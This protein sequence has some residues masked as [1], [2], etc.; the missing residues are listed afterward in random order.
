[1][2]TNKLKSRKQFFLVGPV[3]AYAFYVAM[4]IVA[5]AKPNVGGDQ[6]DFRF[7]TFWG[8][9]I[10]VG[11]AGLSLFSLIRKKS[12]ELALFMIGIGVSLAVI[13]LSTFAIVVIEKDQPASYR[14]QDFIRCLVD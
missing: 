13:F 3:V 6:I 2:K 10:L 5:L 1:M 12:L 9:I 8:V 11:L 7:L 14:C 4:L